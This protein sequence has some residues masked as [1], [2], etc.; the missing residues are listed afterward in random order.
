MLL[1]TKGHRRRKNEEEN[2]K[3]AKLEKR[4]IKIGKNEP[5]KP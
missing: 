4:S 5:Y 2:M 3:D 1:N